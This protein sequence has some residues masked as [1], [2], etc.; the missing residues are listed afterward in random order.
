MKVDS[1]KIIRAV[2]VNRRGPT[3]EEWQTRGGASLASYD[4]ARSITEYAPGAQGALAYYD[5]QTFLEWNGWKES[6]GFITPTLANHAQARSSGLLRIDEPEYYRELALAYRL[7]DLADDIDVVD[8]FGYGA[9]VW[10][11]Y[12]PTL[13]EA[14]WKQKRGKKLTWTPV[15]EGVFEHL[16]P[17]VELFDYVMPLSHRMA[18]EALEY[19]IPADKVAVIPNAVDAEYFS[20]ISEEEKIKIR[21]AYGIKESAAVFICISRISPE[22]NI[23]FLLEAWKEYRTHPETRDSVLLIVGGPTPGDEE[24][25]KLFKLLK[26]KSSENII[27]TGIVDR[28][29]VKNLIGMSDIFVSPSEKEGLAGA[30]LEAMAMAKPSIGDAETSG[31]A[32]VT[33]LLEL[34]QNPNGILFQRG[35]LSQLTQA[36]LTL[37]NMSAAERDD[38]GNNA[39]QKMVEHYNWKTVAEQHVDVYRKLLN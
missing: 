16:K 15:A 2:I 5:T 14:E 37:G 34:S 39:R 38:L 26:D 35:N 29:E 24:M 1:E 25:S 22:K 10:N 36:L 32:D 13:L 8:I 7:F 18:A 9:F 27:C 3:L 11:D 12:F 23:P 6:T 30:L 20:P 31:N 19:G 21:K 33:E 17:P 28:S 4:L